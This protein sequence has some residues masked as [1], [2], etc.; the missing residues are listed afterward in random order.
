MKISAG[1]TAQ[2]KF[3]ARFNGTDKYVDRRSAD[4]DAETRGAMRRRAF[5]VLLAHAI[6]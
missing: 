5:V 1:D 3:L 6:F 4:R 2:E